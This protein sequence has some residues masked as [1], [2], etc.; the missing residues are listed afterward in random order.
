MAEERK[1][2]LV[3]GLGRFGF[4]LCEKLAALNQYV[5]G[6]DA[7]PLK[8][9]E[10]ADIIDLAAQLDATDEDALIKVGAKE[11]D[12]A[13]I[14]IGEN[15]EASILATTIIK[16]FNIPLVVARAQT[17]LHARVLSRVG[18][19]RVIFPERDMGQRVAEQFVHPWLTSFSQLPGG[20]YLVGE[21]T[22][23][24]EMIGKTLAEQE[25]RKKYNAMVLLFDRKGSRFLPSAD[26]VV[27][28]DDRLLIAGKK[29]DLDILLEIIQEERKR[30]GNGA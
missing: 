15:V 20:D 26:T 14:T 25:F 18:A 8:V 30:E 17:A 11:A 5:V 2:I 13:V 10:V 23:L 6:V 28:K 4:S 12:I 16:G 22:P 1:M 19:H 27:E 9:E 29:K 3:V 24:A 7:N 21:I